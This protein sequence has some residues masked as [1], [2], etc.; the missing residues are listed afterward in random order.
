MA[1]G[2]VCK[3]VMRRFK[4]YSHLRFK[5]KNTETL[6]R[7]VGMARFL[8][9]REELGGKTLRIPRRGSVLPSVLSDI[10]NDCI[11]RWHQ[12]GHSAAVI[13]AA[14]RISPRTIVRVIRDLARTGP[15]PGAP[16]RPRRRHPAHSKS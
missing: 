7:I 5:G 2:T 11:Y 1:K 6:L 12:Q 4:S 9:L 3:T 16:A 10:R 14:L 15:P 13:S 8:A